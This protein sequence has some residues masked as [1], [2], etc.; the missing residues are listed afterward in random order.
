MESEGKAILIDPVFDTNPY[1]D[2]IKKRGATLAFVFLTHYHSELLTA[3]AQLGV[4]V[5]MGVGAKR[6]AN[7]FMLQEVKDGEEVHLGSVK[8][9]VIHTPGHTLESSCFLLFDTNQVPVAMF[10]GDTVLVG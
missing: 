7:K 10:T 2:L 6:E 5:V 3:H 1:H 8:I 9:Q 4:P